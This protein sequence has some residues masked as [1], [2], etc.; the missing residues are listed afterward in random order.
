MIILLRVNKITSE[1][2][3]NLEKNSP[4]SDPGSGPNLEN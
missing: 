4:E 2:S 1:K 3:E